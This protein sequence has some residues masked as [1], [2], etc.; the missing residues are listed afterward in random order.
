MRRGL[1]RAWETAR[2]GGIFTPAERAAW[3]AERERALR[4]SADAR[5]PIH[6]ARDAWVGRHPT[7]VGGRVP[8]QCTHVRVRPRD[9]RP[10]H[11]LPPRLS[12]P[13]VNRGK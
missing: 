11:P 13:V 3:D 12:A 9:G 10:T 5:Q 8:T 4:V 1:V 7:P 2:A 6:R